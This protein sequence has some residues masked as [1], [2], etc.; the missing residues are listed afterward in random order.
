M[1]LL[2]SAGGGALD[3][4]LQVRWSGKAFV[5]DTLVFRHEIRGVEFRSLFLPVA[6]VVCWLLQQSAHQQLLRT[7]GDGGGTFK[8]N[9]ILR[10]EVL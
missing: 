10:K 2:V 4:P 9:K 5:G 7:V 3:E 1:C 6:A 8:S